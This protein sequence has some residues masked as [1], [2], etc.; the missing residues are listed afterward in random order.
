MSVDAAS[1]EAPDNLD[2]SL[3]PPE[4]ATTV[5]TESVVGY[6]DSQQNVSQ[7]ALSTPPRTEEN[8]DGNSPVSVQDTNPR[9][10]RSPLSELLVYPSSSNKQKPAAKSYAARILTSAQSI[11]FLEEKKKKKLDEEEE[12]K[13]KRDERAMKKAAKEEEKRRNALEREAKKVEAQ[14]KRKDQGTRKTACQVNC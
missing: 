9:S 12:K 4:R 8:S 1:R 10:G 7:V 2:N 14:Q 11:A 5:T 13:G 3:D 6:S